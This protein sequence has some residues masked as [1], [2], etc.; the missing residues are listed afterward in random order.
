MEGLYISWG[1]LMQA[2]QVH[3]TG[4]SVMSILKTLFKVNVP[5][6]SV[7]AIGVL[8]LLLPLSQRAKYKDYD[9]RL[10][11]LCACLIGVV[12]FNYKA[13]SATYIIPFCGISLWFFSSPKTTA[14]KIIFTGSIV[15]TSVLTSDLVPRAVRQV[16]DVYYFK[17]VASLIVFL[18]IFYE[19][20]SRKISGESFSQTPKPV[21][22]L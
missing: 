8:L 10:L 2:D 1:H 17:A 16:G 22:I 14:K 5:N 6:I 4:L 21:V 20:F 15:L 18:C 19:L 7:E 3:S 13:E 12:I 9:F 11:F